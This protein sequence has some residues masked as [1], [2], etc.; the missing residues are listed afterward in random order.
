VDDPNLIEIPIRGRG[1][2]LAGDLALT[3]FAERV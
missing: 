1:E 3:R 2:A